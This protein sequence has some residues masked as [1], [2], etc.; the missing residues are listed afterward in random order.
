MATL[1][2]LKNDARQAMLNKDFEASLLLYEQIHQHDGKDVRSWIKLADLY[3]KTD[4]QSEAIREYSA[5]AGRYADEGFVVQAIAINKIILRLD[6]KNARA[7]ER[8]AELSR[9]RGEEWDGGDDA[10]KASPHIQ[11]QQTQLLSGLAGQELNAFINSLHLRTAADGEVI[12]RTGEEGKFLFLVGMGAVRL[13]AVDAA[14][15]R[16]V[17]RQLGEGDFFG[18]QAF[19]SRG[20]YRDDAISEGET[21]VM[22]IDRVT[23]DAW[24]EKF[25]NI[26]QTVEEFYRKRVLE[27]VLAVSPLFR[28][29]PADAY[30]ALTSY[31]QRKRFS[32]GEVVVSQGDQGDSCFLIR[33]GKVA[34]STENIRKPGTMID[35]DELSEGEFFGEVALLSDKPR[36]AMVKAVGDVELMELKRDD[37][38][39][40]V[41]EFPA[42]MATVERYQKQRVQS[43]IKKV[44]GGQ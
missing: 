3:V 2:E 7:Q 1:S 43:T 38:S 8:L 40:I 21:A 13:E 14:G 29:I 6:P 34:V 23:F 44:I 17:L 36:T 11:L 41:A 35:L 30:K 18:E 42:V 33:S 12:V 19:M 37:F 27:R 32:D 9:E 24:V 26:Q 39:T 20:E 22:E 15:E 25:P 10:S 5:I 4:K 28:G 16:R 31:F